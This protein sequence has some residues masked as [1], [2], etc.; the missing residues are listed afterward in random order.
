MRFIDGFPHPFFY[1]ALSTQS[2]FWFNED[3]DLAFCNQCTIQT[4]LRPRISKLIRVIFTMTSFKQRT[5]KTVTASSV[6]AIG[7]SHLLICTCF[8]L[9][10]PFR[11]GPTWR[12]RNQRCL[13]RHVYLHH[14]DRDHLPKIYLQIRK[15]DFRWLCGKLHSGRPDS[16]GSFC[17]RH[18]EA[19]LL[20]GSRLER[21]QPDYRWMGNG[22]SAVL[23]SNSDSSGWNGCGWT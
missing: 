8:V 23:G 4:L 19:S 22:S 14:Q 11:S 21:D 7:V 17:E 10:L 5:M 16:T 15:M 2:S 3:Q 9:R 1:L 20:R 6:L 18:G 13:Y 12:L